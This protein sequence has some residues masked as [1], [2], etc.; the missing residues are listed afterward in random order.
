MNTRFLLFFLLISALSSAQDFYDLGTVQTIEITFEESNWD[1]IL[2]AAYATSGDY[3]MATKVIVNGVEFDSVGVKYKG[4]STYQPNQSKNPFH[5]ELNTFKEQDYQ[6]FADIKLSNGSKDPSFIREVLSYQVLRKYMFAPRS[7]FANVYVNGSLIGLYANSESITR[8]FVSDRFGS[9]NNAFF[10]CNPPAGAGPG[11]SDYPNLVYLGQDSS[12]YYSAYELKSETGWQELID[13]CDTLVNHIEDIEKIINVDE[14]LWM[15][16]FNN[17]LV[18]LDSYSGGF[19][20]NYYLYRDSD[21]FFRPIVW[22]LNESFGRFGNSGSGNLN[23]TIQKS[24]LDPFLHENDA[25]FPLIQQLLNI[26]TYRKR[27]IAHLKTIL[28]ENFDNSDYYEVAEA[29][30][31]SID[32]HVEADPNK[33][34]SYQNFLDNLD[35]DVSGGGPG[36]GGGGTPGIANL[37]DARTDYVLGLTDFTNTQPTITD[38]YENIPVINVPFTFVATIADADQAWMYYR[39]SRFDPYERIELFDDGMHD[40]GAAGDGLYAASFT[41]TEVYMQYYVYAENAQ[42]GRFSPERAAFEYYDVIANFGNPNVDAIVIN[43]F[44]ASNDAVEADADGEFDDWIEIYNNSSEAIDL[45]AFYLSDDPDS[46][47][48]WN[49]P[50]GSMIGAGGYFMVWADK[51]LDQEGVH[52]NF[53]ISADGESLFLS[54]L[55]GEIIDEITFLEQTTDVSYG[56]LPNGT[57]DF[58]MMTPSFNA[59]NTNL[60]NAVNFM[61]DASKILLYPN[62]SRTTFS[63]DAQMNGKNN[64]PLSVSNSNGRIL[65]RK[66]ILGKEEVDCSSWPSGVYYVKI[67]DQMMKIVKL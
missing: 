53:K 57:G 28:L 38:V 61:D 37:M 47:L 41:M 13:I 14:A 15:L 5:I 26:S 27:Y 31:A 33:L 44:L 9:R 60:L 64:L 16:A 36:P 22:D 66:V 29:L 20:Q 50:A 46:L 19:T 7:N 11:T 6:G 2:D 12:D 45:N 32:E 21:G 34:F 65:F 1:A 35:N 39:P 25:N 56:R 54:D 23:G 58:Q 52:A 4:N 40:D 51:D 63:I 18:N 24:Q 55:N 3:T 8:R 62:P 67:G 49:F 48:K 17:A 59:Q 43:E 30:R 10:K 42:T